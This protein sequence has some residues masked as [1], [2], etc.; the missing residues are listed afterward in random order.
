MRLLE[1]LLPLGLVAALAPLGCDR[2][3]DPAYPQGSSPGQLG[4]GQLGS[5]DYGPG[6]APP[7]QLPPPGP[8]VGADPINDVAITWLRA[9]GGAVLNEL[10]AALPP[11]FQE[12]V[13]GIPFV[14]EP[15]EGEVNAFAGCDHDREPFMAMTDGLLAVEAYIAQLRATDEVFGTQK[16]DTYLRYM[17]DRQKP[18]QPIVAPP[19]GLIEPAQHHDYRKAV[20]QHQILEE[21]MAFVLGHEL[22]HHYLGHTGCANGQS[23]RRKANSTDV[24]RRLQRVVPIFN[25]PNEDNAD[26]AG[27][28][29]LLTAG[30]RRAGQ[31]YRWSEL[32]ATLTLDF[33]SRV[34]KAPAQTSFEDR[35]FSTVLSSHPNPAQRIPKVQA[36]AYEWRRSGG[37]GYQ[38]IMLR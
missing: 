25:Q 1:R 24:F 16:L 4:V 2:T 23:G 8:P 32:G 6:A 38:P 5:G 36:A 26:I 33:F 11:Q 20:R 29:N 30:A 15:S 28:N 7:V 3:A 9:R 31:A 17:V 27:I 12:R 22:G 37:V 10:V 19:P 21:Q 35:L 14:T 34:D 18:K 13:Q